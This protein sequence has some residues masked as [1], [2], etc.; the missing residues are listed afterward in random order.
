M[1]SIVESRESRAREWRAVR[2]PLRMCLRGWTPGRR[3]L[4]SPRGTVFE[5]RHT[6][7]GVLARAR[8]DF[9]LTQEELRDVPY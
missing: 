3:S 1:K 4:I 2:H 9:Q 7:G 6:A 8:R 5:T